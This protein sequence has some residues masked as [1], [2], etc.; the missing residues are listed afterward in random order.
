MG[1]LWLL[2]NSVVPNPT[3]PLKTLGNVTSTMNA[4]TAS[5]K[6]GCVRTASFLTPSATKES[7]VIIISTWTVVIVWN[8]NLP[9]VPM[10]VPEVERIL[11]PSGPRRLQCLLRLRRG[12]GRRIYLLSRVVVCRVPWCLQLAYRDREVQLQSC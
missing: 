9:K 12:G 1:S 3:E 11:R 6:R 7:L 2:A 5:L 10:P 8:S 4:T